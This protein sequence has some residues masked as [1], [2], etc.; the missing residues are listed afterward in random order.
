M[1]L[2]ETEE[3]A[4]ISNRPNWS[5]PIVLYPIESP[6]TVHDDTQIRICQVPYFF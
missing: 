5:G 6:S 3:W 4:I 2:S 1:S